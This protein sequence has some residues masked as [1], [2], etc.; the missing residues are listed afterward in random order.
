MDT[1]RKTITQASGVSSGNREQKFPDMPSEQ[2]TTAQR[3][4]WLDIAKSQMPPDWRA[5]ARGATPTSFGDRSSV[6]VDALYPVIAPAVAM[7]EIGRA[8]V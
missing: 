8:H 4:K 3:K 5:I 2:P 6:D 7:T 1:M